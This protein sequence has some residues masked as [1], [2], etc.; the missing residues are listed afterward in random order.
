MSK[1][2]THIIILTVFTLSVFAQQ[3]SKSQLQS[4]KQER[5][6]KINNNSNSRDS[7]GD[8]KIIPLNIKDPSGI[9]DTLSYRESLPGSWS[10]NFEFYNQDVILQW[11]EAPADIA[12]LEIGF[13]TAEN[14]D[15]TSVS[16][17]IIKLNLTKDEILNA[18]ELNWGYYPSVGDSFNN[19]APFIDEAT[20]PWVSLT[21]D[22]TEIFGDFLL[23]CTD[24]DTTNC[25]NFLPVASQIDSPIYQFINLSEVYGSEPTILQ[26]EI[27]GIALKNLSTSSDSNRIG[28]WAQEYPAIQGFKYYE[29]GRFTPT[30]GIGWWTQ[31]YVLDIAVV[32]D[33]MVGYYVRF[34][35]TPT[36]T[37][38]ST[39][40]L[41][42]QAIVT[43]ESPG[44]S[45]GIAS[46]L[47]TY[48]NDQGISYTEVPMNM[49]S[50][51][52]YIAG[53][54]NQVPG[55]E[56]IYFI[57]AID[58][59][60]ME[61]VSEQ[62]SFKI[63][64]K[65]SEVL[66]LYNS[67]DLSLDTASY[68]YLG[69]GTADPVVH[70]YWSTA[71]DEITEMDDLLA[72]YKYVIQVD[73]SFPEYDLTINIKNWLDNHT[74]QGMYG[75]LLSSQDY[76]CI[77]SNT[78]ND[79]TFVSGTFQYD[80]L[81]ISGLKQDF[82]IG[83]NLP[84]NIVP[85]QNDPLSDWAF[86]YN[87]DSS[88][89]YW[90]HP[91]Y[92]L[93]FTNWIDKIDFDSTSGATPFFTEAF[94]EN[95][96]A[97]RNESTSFKTAFLTYDYLGS[98]FRSDTSSVLYPEDIDD[99]KYAWGITVRNQAAEFL[100]WAGL[101]LDV[102]NDGNQPD[103]NIPTSFSLSQ[104][105]PNPFNP[106]T[107]I[108]FQIPTNSNVELKV[109]DIL[110]REVATLVNKEFTPGKYEAKLN[111]SNFSSGIYFYQLRAESSANSGRNFVQT[112]KMILLK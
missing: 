84:M 25:P 14:F 99:P 43:V 16:A 33:I 49:V 65:E 57:K 93:G 27:F 70:D 77:L 60:G 17:A 111:A 30:N 20:A 107:V 10:T 59:D 11:Y 29:N 87:N 19:I 63:F 26:G 24:S 89:T 101:V 21:P 53:I 105:Y 15:S 5:H 38:L 42:I 112:K 88:V 90:Y 81:G 86:T 23:N 37:I 9:V 39:N 108:S 73:G 56:I 91:T 67:V 4:S 40:P 35:V 64:K 31:K 72:L 7:W 80:Y 79:T 41:E 75:Y 100:K 109:Y 28:I 32:V 106:E 97:V 102:E 78:C 68:F 83:S 95:V 34:D 85:V 110:G 36:H 71:I 61:W 44:H 52:T 13:T 48:S 1:I 54:P 50:G 58:T 69:N 103:N 45:P 96:V 22:T 66:F 62:Y 94:T 46:V 55:S 8:N 74:R 47:L 98:N 18:G 51:Y 104:N 12:I 92:E 3:Y 82:S 6:K 76:G 2:L